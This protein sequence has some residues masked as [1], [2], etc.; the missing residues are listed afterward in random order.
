[1]RGAA[2]TV[3]VAAALVLLAGILAML[4]YLSRSGLTVNVR[5]AVALEGSTTGVTG[6]VRLVM[7]EPVA[8]VATGPDAGPVAARLSAIPCPACGGAMLPVRWRPLSGEIEWR[9]FVCDLTTEE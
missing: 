4:V 8:M 9:C 5:G 6:D 3:A 2:A 1:V 7:D